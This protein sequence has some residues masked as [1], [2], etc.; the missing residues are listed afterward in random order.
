[1]KESKTLVAAASLLLA[2]TTFFTLGSYVDAPK[3]RL[4]SGFVWIDSAAKKEVLNVSQILV[5][6]STWDPK[7]PV[8][9][10][11]K[12]NAK[13]TFLKMTDRSILTIREGMESFLNRA[14]NQQR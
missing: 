5:I 9:K 2:S 4:P 13:W 12:K 10:R 8:A 6:T 3:D 7:I 14:R 1:M 11:T